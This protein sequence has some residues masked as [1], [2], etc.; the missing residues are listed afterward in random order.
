[1]EFRGSVNIGNSE[2]S[3]DRGEI[4]EF[5]VSYKEFSLMNIPYKIGTKHRR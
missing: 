3:R 4:S 1:M 2:V 5:P